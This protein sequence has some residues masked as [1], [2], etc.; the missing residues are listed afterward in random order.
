MG[1]VGV[2]LLVARCDERRG[3]GAGRP[4]LLNAAGLLPVAG[5]AAVIGWAVASH[6]RTAP[7]D[8][9]VTL[10]PSYLVQNGAYAVSRNPLYLGGAAMWAGWAWFFG[11]RRVMAVGAAWAGAIVTIGVP[12]EERL[13][14]ARFGQAY[15]AYRDKVPRWLRL[16]QP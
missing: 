16:R 10:T 7:R 15:R 12:F 2:P 9:A 4:G 8:S 3:W 6:Y 5:G 14:D 13:L 1:Y 11:S